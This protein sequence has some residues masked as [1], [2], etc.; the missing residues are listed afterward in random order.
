[1][2]EEVNFNHAAFC[3]R[4]FM[5]FVNHLLVAMVAAAVS[6]LITWRVASPPGDDG[7]M[8]VEALNQ[9]NPRDVARRLLPPFSA[10][11]G[12]RVVDISIGSSTSSERPEDGARPEFV[13]FRLR[14]EGAGQGVCAAQNLTVGLGPPP[15]S[16]RTRAASPAAGEKARQ[17]GI[18]TTSKPIAS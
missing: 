10:R 15:G 4:R 3:P 14:A 7:L 6:A 8:S 13:S 16:V 5:K 1:M 11:L 9:S 12:E 18:T 17:T 2:R